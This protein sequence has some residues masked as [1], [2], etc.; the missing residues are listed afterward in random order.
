MNTNIMVAVRR[1]PLRTRV[2]FHTQLWSREG[3]SREGGG[4]VG[5]A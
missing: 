2:S 3:R 4:G 5:T 1:R